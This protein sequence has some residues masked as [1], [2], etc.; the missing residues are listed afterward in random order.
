MEKVVVDIGEKEFAL[1]ITYV[2]FSRAT[3][4]KALMIDCDYRAIQWDRFEKI[5]GNV[6]QQYRR[7]IDDKLKETHKKTMGKNWSEDTN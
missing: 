6:Q 4:W 2:G 1:G 7:G 3:H 5:N